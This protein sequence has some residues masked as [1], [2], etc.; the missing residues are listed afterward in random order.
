MGIFLTFF[1]ILP[2]ET[3]T[4]HLPQDPTIAGPWSRYK[5]IGQYGGQGWGTTGYDHS[6]VAVNII[7]LSAI[8]IH[9][10]QSN[11]I[12]WD[13]LFLLITVVTCFFTESRTG[14]SA[15]IV[16]AMIYWFKKPQ[17]T[18]KIIFIFLF[19]LTLLMFYLFNIGYIPSIDLVSTEGSLLERQS[20]LA[21]IDSDSLSGRDEIWSERIKLITE[22]NE[23]LLWGSGFGAATDT[24]KKAHLLLLHIT[25][26]TGLIGLSIFIFLFTHIFYYLY[27]YEADIKAIFIATISFFV[28]ALGQDTL[29]FTVTFIHFT[30]FYLY[31]VAIALN[32]YHIY[33]PKSNVAKIKC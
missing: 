12:L 28:S 27:T 7:M 9:L 8:R 25:L 11:N 5:L 4:L 21:N 33:L 3:L 13:K 17:H 14:L 2:L 10:A 15:S 32:K 20:T 1:N 26:E 19:L 6:L 16:F 30:G 23:L 24:G 22:N 18:T 31:G 29:Y